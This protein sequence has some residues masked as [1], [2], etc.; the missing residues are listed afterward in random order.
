MKN[1]VYL[2]T[3]TNKVKST[4]YAKFDEAHFSYEQKPPGARILMELGMNEQPV[5]SQISPTDISLK[6]IRKHPDSIVPSKGTTN[7]AGFDLCSIETLTIPPQHVGLVD[8]GITAI[9]LLKT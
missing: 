8:T 3:K 7:S 9:F 6:I 1:I 2:D 5:P 4:T